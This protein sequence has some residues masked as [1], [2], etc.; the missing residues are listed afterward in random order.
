MRLF[1]QLLLVLS[2]ALPTVSCGNKGRLKSPAQ[3]EEEEAKKA[4]RE[5]KEAKKKQEAAPKPDEAVAPV[6]EK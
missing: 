1:I 3:I 6:E 5:A 2:L 4:A